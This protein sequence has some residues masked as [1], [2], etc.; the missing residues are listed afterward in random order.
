MRV[1]NG[2][3][4][5]R[6]LEGVGLAEQQVLVVERGDRAI[7]VQEGVAA[8]LVDVLEGPAED[9]VGLGVAVVV[10]VEQVARVG[11][12]RVEV[13]AAV[14]LLERLPVAMNET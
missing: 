9:G 10:D 4:F 6:R 5:E 8:T 3:P 14:G 2:S 13:R 12:E 11:G 7:V 1:L